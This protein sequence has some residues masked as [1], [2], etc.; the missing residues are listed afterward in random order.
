M[1]WL[2]P[3]GN[4]QSCEK[5]KSAG[6]SYIFNLRLKEAQTYLKNVFRKK[7]LKKDQI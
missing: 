1:A 4:W 7:Y 2:F 6:T 5:S 3:A